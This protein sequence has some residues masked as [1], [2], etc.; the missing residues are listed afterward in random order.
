MTRSAFLAVFAMGLLLIPAFNSTG[1]VS[2]QR[3]KQEL[4]TPDM[5]GRA[6]NL[7]TVSGY[8]AFAEN[9]ISDNG[10]SLIRGDVGV[11]RP[12]AEIKGI[13]GA[14]VK[15]LIQDQNFDSLRVQKDFSDSFSAINQLPCT[16][17]SDTNLGGRKFT[18]GIYCLSS[19]RLAGDMVL[20]GGNDA[21]GVFI[22]RV[23]GTLS[24]EKGSSVSLTN[25]AQSANVFFVA[26]DSTSIG[27]NSSVKGNLMARGSITV[28]SG[29]TVEG[30][31]LS[32]KGDVALNGNIL[33]P[34]APGTLEIC[35]A[36]DATAGT[37]LENNI[38]L[39]TAAG[40]TIA[41]QAG[42]CSGQISIEAGQVTIEEQLSGRATPGNS[43]NPNFQLVGVT[44]NTNVGQAG[45][46]ALVS[47]NLPLRQAVV[48]IVA[49]TSPTG[50]ASDQTRITFTNRFA[51]TAI[52][53]ICK[54]ALDSGVNGFFNFTINGL[55]PG[56]STVS[57]GTTVSGTPALQVFTVP[58]G[59]CTGAIQVTAASTNAS[60]PPRTGTVTVNELS[61][62]GFIFTSAS[63]A[64]GTAGGGTAN[65]N[66][67]Q[68]FTV[69]APGS[70]IAGSAT[71]TVVQ[72]GTDIQTTFFFNNRTAPGQLKICKVAG[73][74]ITEGTAFLFDVTGTAPTAPITTATTI[75][76]SG[77]TNGSANGG[78]NGQPG[79]ANIGASLNT[80][81]A[82]GPTRV[83]VTA[84]LPGATPAV[85]FSGGFCQIVPGT[86]VV[87]T[88]VTI[89]EVSDGT[90]VVIAG[91]G[92]IGDFRVTRIASSTGIFSASGT[93]NTS[94]SA[95]AANT[96]FFPNQSSTTFGGTAASRTV[97]V[98]IRRGVTEVEF[99]NTALSPVPLKICKVAG[100]SALVGTPFT[101]TVNA[102]G[103]G[104]ASFGLVQASTSTV[105]VT[106][107]AAGSGPGAQNGN[108]AFVGG[109]F[110]GNF[111][112]TNNNAQINGMGSFNFNSGLTITETATT[113]VVTSSI[114]SPTGGVV[115][116]LSTGTATISNM[117][118]GV[119]EVTFVNST[120]TGATP[121]PAR[122]KKILL[123]PVATF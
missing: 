64:N 17:V 115:G 4:A 78:T 86:F 69:N 38:F 108:C 98:P 84:G 89:S 122:R 82:V 104:T 100:S 29:A 96:A 75:G 120:A 22:F 31:A 119:N 43:F 97:T 81:M 71:A 33:G 113:G 35:K 57:G 41:V 63:T 67:L 16:E 60:G 62:F 107:G 53:E 117:I 102:N 123:S 79:T 56:N 70:S 91:T 68:S 87:D 45:T 105:T 99:V 8:S 52:V 39:F 13:N 6:L 80:G 54:Q 111:F 101:F 112:G 83:Q 21:S 61:R 42:Q 30:R 24:T 74:G 116:N 3:E 51:I 58:T 95:V 36:I 27:E 88:S 93:A 94:G 48:N 118:N 10:N 110:G 103:A 11:A 85:P 50:T 14:N 109:Q 47:A 55:A 5:I 73:P 40:Q 92:V 72:G 19:A 15:G 18:P 2:A 66:R 12:T 106:A 65:T 9:G 44:Q 32:L 46:T 1:T 37:G 77:T 59:Q 28:D 114:T 90:G 76:N 121:A 26:D 20:D 7:R 49:S 23:A 34:Q 25:S